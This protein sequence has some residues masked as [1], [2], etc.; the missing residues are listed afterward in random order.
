MLLGQSSTGAVLG[1]VR[2]P[3]GAA[4]PETQVKLKNLGTGVSLQFATDDTGNYYFPSLIPGR[5][6]VEAE[7]PGFRKVTVTDIRVEVD[8]SAR[9]LVQTDSVAVGQVVSNRQVSEL[10]LNGR[11]FT[12]LLR[13]N[14]GVSEVQGGIIT[15]TNIWRHGLNDNFRNVSVNGAR[16]ASI[17]F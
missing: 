3:T 2:D 17:S 5:Y 14:A 4:V 16:P 8:Q 10:P 12:N 9:L 15:S 1:T 13:L 11:D 7:K 6:Q